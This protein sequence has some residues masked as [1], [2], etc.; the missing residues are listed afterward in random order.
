MLFRA[1][2]YQLWYERKATLR[3]FVAKK[4]RPRLFFAPAGNPQHWLRAHHARSIAHFRISVK[5][6]EMPD[7]ARLFRDLTEA[8]N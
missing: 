4:S 1:S 5:S 6:A 8:W 3:H 2:P 7:L